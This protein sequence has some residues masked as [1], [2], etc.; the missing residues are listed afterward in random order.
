MQNN[1][2]IPQIQRNIVAP[3]GDLP[4]NANTQCDAPR[5][6]LSLS[7]VGECS[8]AGRKEG[9]ASESFLGRERGGNALQF[10]HTLYDVLLQHTITLSITSRV[11]CGVAYRKSLPGGQKN[12]VLVELVRLK[13]K[14]TP[15][16]PSPKFSTLA[17]YI[18]CNSN[19]TL[20]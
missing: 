15:P 10:S 12:V 2:G 6:P 4:Q 8:D 9:S 17:G 5:A 11:K 3:V 18:L 19:T 13:S 1:V 7:C 16:F 20:N 14:Q